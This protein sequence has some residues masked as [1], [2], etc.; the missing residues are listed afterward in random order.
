MGVD[1]ADHILLRRLSD[2]S[3]IRQGSKVYPACRIRAACE[4]KLAF[5]LNLFE[6]SI[7]RV[8]FLTADA[9]C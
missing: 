8:D 5:S 3:P 9:T 6:H 1:H 4:L 2:G 7:G